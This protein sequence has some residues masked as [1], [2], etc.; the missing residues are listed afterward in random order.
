[1]DSTTSDCRARRNQYMRVALDKLQTAAELIRLQ[2][3][4]LEALPPR[5]VTHEQIH[6][7]A[8]WRLNLDA[9]CIDKLIE[10]MQQAVR[11]TPEISAAIDKLAN[12]IAALPTA[13]QYTTV[14]DVGEDDPLSE[15]GAC[16]GLEFRIEMYTSRCFP[17]PDEEDE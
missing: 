2:R 4:I 3:V 5:P 8:M 9:R 7:A 17:L 10:L 1:M 16:F 14:F 15:P 11:F 6:D 13:E 12:S